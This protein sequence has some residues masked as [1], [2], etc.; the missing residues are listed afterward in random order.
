MNKN[1]KWFLALGV[2]AMVTANG[3]AMAAMPADSQ[4][5]V[6]G[7]R[8][9]FVG[10][11]DRPEMK[12]FKED[13]AKLLALLK[14]DAETF[15]SE[16]KAGKTMVT[17]AK[18]HGVSE[19]KLKDFVV[20][21]M[22]TR[23]EEGV[24]TGHI[25]AEQ[26]AK[27]KAEMDSRVTD[28]IN[29][30]G[31]MPGG[32]GHRPGHAPFE[33]AKLL[34]LLKVDAETLKSEMKAGKTLATVAR[35][36]GVSEQTLQD[37]LVQQMTERID[38]GVKAGR[39]TEEKAD[40]MKADLA[41][42][43]ADMINGKGPMRG[44]PGMMHGQA[45]FADAKLLALLNI[46][47]ETLQKEMKDN[48]KTLVTIAKEQG[49]SEQALKNFLTEQMTERINEGVKSGRLSAEQA[50]KMKADMDT[51]ITDMINGKGPMHRG[52]GPQPVPEEQQ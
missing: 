30:K 8:H 13:H 41:T 26:A 51:R 32:F 24:K 19:K 47:A 11:E 40:K 31:P 44:G 29:G 27:M 38:E 22:T 6:D 17:I 15:R 37:F 1:K 21:Q 34:A 14:I 43:V 42:R 33:D 46:D 36:H 50:E 39:L 2:A 20:K 5:T 28:M 18:E 16:I 10:K 49:V 48:H 9:A 35:A 25:T 45:P 7:K 52:H 23:L 12:G 4:N 3:I